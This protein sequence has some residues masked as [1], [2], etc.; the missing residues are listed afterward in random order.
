M[1]I[2]IVFYPTSI[3]EDYNLELQY[4]KPFP[5]VWKEEKNHSVFGPLSER[6][7]VRGRDAGPLLV[8]DEEMEAAS[9]TLSSGL[10]SISTNQ[11]YRFLSCLLLLQSLRTTFWTFWRYTIIVTSK[12]PKYIILIAIFE[13][14]I[15]RRKIKKNIRYLGAKLCPYKSISLLFCM[16]VEAS[17]STASSRLSIFLPKEFTHICSE[18]A[19]AARKTASAFE[20]PRLILIICLVV[21][22]F[23]SPI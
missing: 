12:I 23:T 19:G 22:C 9:T 6:M 4:R 20:E 7:G 5:E 15:L 8:S 18:P 1:A 11:M 2:L 14:D 21:Q 3:A 10:M 17:L 13:M 16:R